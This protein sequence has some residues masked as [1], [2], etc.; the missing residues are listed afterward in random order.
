MP[1]PTTFVDA[2]AYAVS[3]RAKALHDMM[4]QEESFPKLGSRVAKERER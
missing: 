4:F 2:C 3:Y 1:L